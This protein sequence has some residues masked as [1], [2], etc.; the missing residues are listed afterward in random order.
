MSLSTSE[1]ESLRLHL[2]YGNLSITALPYTPDGW[3]EVFGTIVSDAL[4]T[5]TETS[6]STAVT[7]GAVTTITVAD[8]SEFSVY[9]EA[10]IDVGDNAE[11]VV[12]Q[13][14]TTGGTETLTAYFEKAHSASGYPVATMSG[15]A[16]LRMLLH[17]ANRAWRMLT[18][19]SVGK[20]SGIKSVDKEDVVFFGGTS[21]SSGR[22]SHYQSIVAAISQ[23]V[24]VPS[25]WSWPGG[26]I[27]TVEAY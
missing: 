11:I 18:D 3:W 22:L 19:S 8:A 16:R 14:C 2:G 6:G 23:L 5:G 27:T 1:V 7:A 9:D 20:A 25:A 26:G 17:D 21:V 4:G 10:V 12:I 13:A 24:R 15:K